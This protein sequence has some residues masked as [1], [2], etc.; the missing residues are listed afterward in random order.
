MSLSPPRERSMNGQTR[1][2][3]LYWCFR[4]NRTVRLARDN[5]TGITCPRCSDQFLTE[6]TVPRPRLVVDFTAHDPSPEARLL[7]ALSLMLD[8]PIRR[9]DGTAAD[10]RTRR[11]SR[12]FPP[13]DETE[14]PIWLP[15]H[16]R[17]SSD[18]TRPD[19]YGAGSGPRSTQPRTWVILQP[20]DAP[21]TLEPVVPGG[22][23]TRDYFAGPGLNELIE[24]LT[25]NDRQGPA[26]V[27]VPE[28]VIE[29]VPRVRIESGHLKENPHCPVC[30]E[31]FEVGGEARELPCKHVYHSDCIV[32]WLRLNNS[33]PVCRNE[34]P[35]SCSE[36]EEEG[37]EGDGGGGRLRRCLRWTRLSSL[38]PFHGRR[39]HQR[40]HP[41]AASS[42][43]TNPRQQHSCC[44][45]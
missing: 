42:S 40:V 9:F 10:F 44:I 17:R 38:W 12:R 43:A 27:P 32:P 25:E 20:F 37:E 31:D 33:C 23:D 7:E 15:R 16:R 29:A 18:P 24:Q 35:V 1:T 6:I 14:T 36:E 11:P 3:Q 45:L 22:V 13:P 2:Y 8:P 41:A 21:G 34:I 28:R 4:C 19:G 30:Q 39:Y 26:P 5:P